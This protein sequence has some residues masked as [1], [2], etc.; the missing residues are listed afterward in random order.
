VDKNAKAFVL[1]DL[2]N[3]AAV[4]DQAVASAAERLPGMRAEYS[5]LFAKVGNCARS[6]TELDRLEWHQKSA[7]RDAAKARGFRRLIEKIECHGLPA[8]WGAPTQT[9]TPVADSSD[10]R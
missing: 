7:A 9:E 2:E 1:A 5:A 4:R 6:N 10:A 8:P 3:F